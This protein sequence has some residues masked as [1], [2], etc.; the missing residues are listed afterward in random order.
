MCVDILWLYVGSE[1]AVLL[2]ACL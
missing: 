2:S 1:F